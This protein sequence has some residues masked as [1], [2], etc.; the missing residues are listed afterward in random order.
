MDTK[1]AGG[2][3]LIVGTSIGAGM[4][5]LPIVTAESGFLMSVLTMFLC[6]GIMTFSAFL[7]LE[8][9]LW[10]PPGNNII[11]MA[12]KTLGKPGALVAWVSFLLLLYTLL[13]AFIS[14]GSDLFNSLTAKTG[15]QTPL[16]LDSVLFVI[17]FGF[18]VFRGIKPVD[19]V[20]RA[21]M[22]IKL[23]FLFILIS[24]AFPHVKA[25]QLAAG[26]PLLF[27]STITVTLTSFGFA[28]IIP[29]LRSYFDSDIKKLRQAILIG[30][31]IPFVCY[32]FWNLSIL[33]AVP[34]DNILNIMQTGGSVALLTQSLSDYLNNDSISI[35]AHI[36]TAICVLTS[37]LC[38]SL[39]LVDFLADGLHIKK[40]GFGNIIINCITFLPPLILVIFYPS[41]FTQ[42]L[43]YAGIICL[44][45]LVLLPA[46]MVY[47]GR[48]KKG[49]SIGHYQV[50]GGRGAV[51]FLG[52]LAVFI[53]SLA[54]KE[55]F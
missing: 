12:K 1:I 28:N 36:F 26:H 51:I 44:V 42:A 47:S 10:M 21:L 39:S 11:T 40:K 7:I 18:I 14:G 9:N 4:L 20:N 52:I 22:T 31:L 8:V 17:I 55:T 34:R 30:S 3:L 50:L 32:F 6:W 54:V 23:T 41:I 53:I 46:L 37:F 19:Y 16:W 25:Q 33:G 43:N 2:I 29:S 49:L 13:S 24:F 45:L 38:V 48:Y 15:L 35:I 5:A 27:T